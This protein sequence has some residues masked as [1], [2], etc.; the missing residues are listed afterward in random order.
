MNISNPA[1]STSEKSAY[2]ISN[3]DPKPLNAEKAI[4]FLADQAKEL[5]KNNFSVK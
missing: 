4:T 3:N 5:G 2:S 1:I